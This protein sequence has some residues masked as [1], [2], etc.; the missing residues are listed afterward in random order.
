MNPNILTSYF[1]ET[2]GDMT[3]WP[4]VVTRPTP[5]VSRVVEFC[6][7]LKIEGSVGRACFSNSFDSF[8]NEER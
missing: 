4:S 5:E 2:S 1:A 3:H 7:T 8:N 6:T